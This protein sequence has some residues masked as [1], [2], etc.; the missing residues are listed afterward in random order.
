METGTSANNQYLGNRRRGDRF[1][2]REAVQYKVSKRGIVIL[3]GT[4]TTL[5]FSTSGIQ[6][7]TEG[8]LPV[9]SLI[10]ISVDWPAQLNDNCALKFVATG[11]V[12]RSEPD[13]AAV[14]IQRHEFRT[15]AKAATGRTGSPEAAVQPRL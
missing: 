1:P 12:V 11:R 3:R 14:E 5:N 13:R 15:R 10:E 4:G 2:I 6:F 7:T 9:G 8:Q